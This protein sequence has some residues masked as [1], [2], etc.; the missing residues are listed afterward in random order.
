[1]T[2]SLDDYTRTLAEVEELLNTTSSVSFAIAKS[3]GEDDQRV[4]DY[5]LAHRS[6]IVAKFKEHIE[7]LEQANPC[8]IAQRS[9]QANRRTHQA[10][11][12]VFY[13]R[14]F[15]PELRELL[16][17]K[18]GSELLTLGEVLGTPSREWV[19]RITEWAKKPDRLL[20]SSRESSSIREQPQR[21]PAE[22]QKFIDSHRNAMMR[23]FSKRCDEMAG[24][25][26]TIR[27]MIESFQR[28]EQKK[29]AKVRDRETKALLTKALMSLLTSQ[30]EQRRE[31]ADR[32]PE[33]HPSPANAG[34][35]Q[36]A[37]L[38]DGSEIDPLVV[39]LLAKILD[40]TRDQPAKRRGNPKL[41]FPAKTWKEAK[42]HGFYESGVGRS[43][44]V[45][46]TE[47]GMQFLRENKP[48]LFRES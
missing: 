34:S 46:L 14:K 25:A 13:S 37:T 33:A 8:E 41:K 24:T 43:G 39:D 31:N 28:A 48:E 36:P 10:D 22:V 42:S 44:S 15:I 32:Q 27:Q 26:K 45:W 19:E 38:K 7:Q 17:G 1:M 12:L 47:P 20:R 4:H 11:T 29:E 5:L 18:P 23:R 2:I 40:A 16:D 9:T 6:D 21:D 35:V 30:T 3:R